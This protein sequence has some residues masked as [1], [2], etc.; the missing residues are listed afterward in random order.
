MSTTSTA[1]SQKPSMTGTLIQPYLDFAGRCE[2]ALKFYE[3]AVGA[4]IDVVM[5]FNESPDPVPDGML[6][7]GFEKKVM[8]SQFR[9]GAS[10]VMATDG[11]NAE[12]TFQGFQLS[13]SVPTELDADRVFAALSDG[14]KVS[15]PL[16]KTFWSP[17]FGMLQDRFGVSWMVIVPDP[18]Y[19]G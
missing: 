13:I 6:A 10:T 19:P 4:Q 16:C 9:V 2:E 12:G 8:H 7:P 17:R 3:K 14:G 18:N 5:H 15:M 1:P 11:C